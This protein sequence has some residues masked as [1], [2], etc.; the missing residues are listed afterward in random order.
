MLWFLEEDLGGTRIRDP[1]TITIKTNS[2]L[3]SLEGQEK[4]GRKNKML[5]IV[6]FIWTFFGENDYELSV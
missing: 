1:D 4:E 3:S 6:F 5:C 2:T